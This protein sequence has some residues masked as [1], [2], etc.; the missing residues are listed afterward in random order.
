M[1]LILNSYKQLKIPE[2]LALSTV[3]GVD[4]NGDYEADE[5]DTLH[6]SWGQLKVGK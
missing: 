6:P 2:S 4:E 3:C 1:K 5:H